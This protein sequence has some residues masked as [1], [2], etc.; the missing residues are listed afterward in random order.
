MPQSIPLLF[1]KILFEHAVSLLSISLGSAC[2]LRAPF[3]ASDS[4]IPL[5]Y[6]PAHSGKSLR[7]TNLQASRFLLVE[8]KLMLEVAPG[9]YTWEIHWQIHM[10][11][12]MANTHGKYTWEVHMNYFTVYHFIGPYNN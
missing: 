8:V 9:K 5:Q 2:M 3:G 1:G 11:I 10:E 6:R 12:H 4:N 7:W